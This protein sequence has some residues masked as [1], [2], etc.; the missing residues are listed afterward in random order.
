M[1]TCELVPLFV[2]W[3]S[4]IADGSF[5]LL[6]DARY[7]NR[8]LKARVQITAAE[9]HTGNGVVGLLLQGLKSG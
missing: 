3:V 9:I 2:L 7:V 4:G 8:W 6:A 5:L 1:P